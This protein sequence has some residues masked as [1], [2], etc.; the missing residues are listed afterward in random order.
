[1][2]LWLLWSAEYVW[3][4]G[5]PYPRLWHVGYDNVKAGGLLQYPPNVTRKQEM[6]TY[7]G[8]ALKKMKAAHRVLTQ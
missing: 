8:K 3:G 7:A 2:E 4:C 1:M 5:L 6:S